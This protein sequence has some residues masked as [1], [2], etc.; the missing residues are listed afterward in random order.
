MTPKLHQAI[1]VRKGRKSQ[2]DARIVELNKSIGKADQYNGMSRSYRPKTDDGERYPDENKRVQAFGLDVLGDLRGLY[3]ELIDMEAQVDVANCAAHADIVV[4]GEVIVEDVPA[5]HLLFL[6]KRFAELRGVVDQ[7]PTLDESVEWR[8]DENRDGLFRG[9]AVEKL[10]TQKKKVVI[11]LAKPTD[12]HPEQT[13]LVDE[14]VITGTW[15]ESKLSGALPATQK[16]AILARFDTLIAAVKH[17]RALANEAEAP[18][19]QIGAKLLRYV[20]PT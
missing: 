2:L 14:D 4:N 5:T 1:A 13:A 16:A 9:D 12:K 10:R 15:T 18:R 11:S 7:L 20:F 3:T 17:A 19:V 8:R 6:E